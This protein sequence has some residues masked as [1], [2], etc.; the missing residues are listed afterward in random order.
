MG[1]KYRSLLL[2]LIP[3]L[4]LS[5]LLLRLVVIRIWCIM[6]SCE[7]LSLKMHIPRRIDLR[8]G[9]RAGAG[10]NL[11]LDHIPAKI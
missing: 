2:L 10:V 7:Q 8:S 11:G 9:P 3:V 6:G 5:L 4:L 1:I